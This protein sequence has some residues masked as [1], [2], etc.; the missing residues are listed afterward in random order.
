[1]DTPK[2]VLE[3][4]STPEPKQA[5]ELR[6]AAR[7]IT[8]GMQYLLDDA[9]V[10]PMRHADGVTDLKWLLTKL[11]SGTWGLNINPKRSQQD[12]PFP[13][14]QPETNLVVVPPVPSVPPDG[15]GGD[16]SNGRE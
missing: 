7:A 16:G 3:Q 9:V 10:G 5:P 13:P 1:M 14:L 6:R 12:A 15:A 11:I 2:E 8:G 4:G